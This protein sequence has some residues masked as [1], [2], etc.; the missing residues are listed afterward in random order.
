MP[1]FTI[2]CVCQ[3]PGKLT[4]IQPP[5]SQNTHSSW[6]GQEAAYSCSY[7]AL[8]EQHHEILLSCFQN[9]AV[10]TG[11]STPPYKFS[12]LFMT[13]SAAGTRE[14]T[15]VR[16]VSSAHE[17][18]FQNLLKGAVH[19]PWHA[20]LAQSGCNLVAHQNT[21]NVEQGAA[22]VSPMLSKKAALVGKSIN[23][24]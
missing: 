24:A 11:M 6:K 4:L 12:M 18:A 3:S 23:P 14:F 10:E 9:H 19:P 7:T 8:L 13:A 17:L 21:C 22:P 2:L 20:S 1:P 5:V 16:D 15:E